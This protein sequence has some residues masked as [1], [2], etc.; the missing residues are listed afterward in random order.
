[1]AQSKSLKKA[2]HEEMKD[3]VHDAKTGNV[4]TADDPADTAPKAP[5]Q[6]VDLPTGQHSH[7]G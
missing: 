1:M 5:K 3:A 4:A 6:P 2:V 7:P